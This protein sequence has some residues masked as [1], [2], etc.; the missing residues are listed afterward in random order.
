MKEW[1]KLMKIT[2]EML[3]ADINELKDK[4]DYNDI[5]LRA[6]YIIALDYVKNLKIKKNTYTLADVFERYEGVQEYQGIV[7]IIQK[8]YYGTLV[9]DAWC[10]TALSWALDKM[11]LL[12][13]GMKKQ[14]NVYFLWNE[15][16]NQVRVGHYTL[17]SKTADSRRG[18]III[19]NFDKL[20]KWSPT[21]SKHVTVYT[22][23]WRNGMFV[24]IGGNQS[25]G[26]NATW[27][28]TD[29]IVNI[30]RPDYSKSTLKSLEELPN[31]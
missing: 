29:C 13:S 22:G 30:F 11:G 23:D 21:C 19:L 12:S 5:M 25:N 6:T 16:M 24:G 7:A 18:D 27:Y 3:I 15:L 10:A 8:W 20:N 28:S 31:V 17:I 4:D 9:K 14:E 2:P 1:V 26:F